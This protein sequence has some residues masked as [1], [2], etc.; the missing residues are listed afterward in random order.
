[1]ISLEITSI[2]P[3]KYLEPD[4]W[5]EFIIEYR[6]VINELFEYVSSQIPFFGFVTQ[7]SMGQF[8]TD[9]EF[10]YELMGISDLSGIF[11]TNLFTMNFLYELMSVYTFAI[12]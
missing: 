3:L 1:M 10:V 2:S 11:Y 6:E 8:N 12:V 4:R 9:R 7:L 5:K